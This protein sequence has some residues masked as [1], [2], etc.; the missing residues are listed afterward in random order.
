MGDE[1]K[2]IPFLREIFVFN[3]KL[4]TGKVG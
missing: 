2:T 1:G 4:K 3:W